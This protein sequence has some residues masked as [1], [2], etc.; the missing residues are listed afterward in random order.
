MPSDAAL[1]PSDTLWDDDADQDEQQSSGMP[2]RRKVLLLL[3][4]LAV[5]AA[6][7][8]AAIYGPT[9]WRISQEK[10]TSLSTPEQ[11]GGLRLDDSQQAKD[12][13]D[14]LRDALGAAISLKE[15][16]GAVYSDANAPT[17]SVILVGGTATFREPDQELTKA[18]GLL[19][20]ENGQVQNVSTVPPGDLGGT[21]K[22]GTTPGADALVICGWADHG[23][24]VMG[25][26]PGRE[27]GESAELLRNLRSTIQHRR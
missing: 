8:S 16:I 22:C 7:A 19:S 25:M 6:A 20:G 17:K 9:A 13:A 15:S 5:A 3:G 10:N 26:F 23:S 14:Y 27:V 24:I 1:P 18:F 12:T 4:G 2:R 11:V 21:M